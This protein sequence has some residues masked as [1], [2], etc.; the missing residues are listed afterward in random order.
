[1][2]KRSARPPAITSSGRD[3]R[4][5]DPVLHRQQ[6]DDQRHDDAEADHADPE[7]RA[8]RPAEEQPGGLDVRLGRRQQADQEE[9]DEDQLGDQEAVVGLGQELALAGVRRDE[10]HEGGGGRE[11]GD[12]KERA[13]EGAVPERP[14][15]E[16]REQDAG[17]DAEQPAP[18]HVHRPDP[19]QQLRALDQPVGEL[20]RAPAPARAAAA[21]TRSRRLASSA[22]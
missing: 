4:V 16:G 5:R 21:G 9:R 14:G 7:E 1:M 12:Q 17:V 15:A 11:A 13:E 20:A 6:L 3:R 8:E 22:G 18:D 10:V 19:A 2:T